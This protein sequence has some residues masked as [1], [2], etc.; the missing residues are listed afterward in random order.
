MIPLFLPCSPSVTCAENV[1]MTVLLLLPQLCQCNGRNSQPV[2]LLPLWVLAN[3]I[4]GHDPSSD[5]EQGASPLVLGDS[6]C[7]R[8]HRDHTSSRSC[9]LGKCVRELNSSWW[10]SW[11]AR[12]M[13]ASKSLLR[14]YEPLDALL[15]EELDV[16]CLQLSTV[17][18]C[19][20]RASKNSRLFDE[21]PEAAR[22]LPSFF[23]LERASAFA[24]CLIVWN[25]INH[26]TF[27]SCE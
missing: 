16:A 7:Q 8:S 19:L 10:G 12:L 3:V 5:P 22:F 9:S 1:L 14:L 15:L 2:L 6:Q 24:S 18:V 27:Y 11:C 26:S 21:L 13:S 25:L 20:M 4:E 17:S 23:P